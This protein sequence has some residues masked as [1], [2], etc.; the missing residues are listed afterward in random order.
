MNEREPIADITAEKAFFDAVGIDPS[1][2]LKSSNPEDDVEKTLEFAADLLLQRQHQ[3]GYWM[4]EL[5]ADVTIPSEY[6]LLQLF[7]GKS[8]DQIQTRISRYLLKAQ[9]TDGSWPLFYDGEG[10]IS[11]TVKAYF[12]LKLAGQDPESEHM[13]LARQWIID[14][15]GAEHCNVFTRITLALFGQIPWRTVPAMPAEIIWIPN[16]WFFSL[17]KVSYWSRCV[18]VPLLILLAYRPVYTLKKNQSIRELF[19]QDPDTLKNLETLSFSNP[20]KSVFYLLDRFI[21]LVQGY[22]PRKIRESSIQRCETWTREHMKGEGGIGAIFPAMANAVM[23][24][25][26]RGCTEDDPDFLRGYMAIQDLVVEKQ[27]EIY[28]QPCVSPIWDTCLT[29]NALAE[30]GVSQDHPGMLKAISWLF[31]KQIFFKGDWARRRPQLNCGAWAF[32]F[33]NDFYPDIDDTSMVVMSLLRCNAHLNPEYFERIKQA[34]DWVIGM[35]NTDGGWGAFDLNNHYEYLNN[36]PF[37]DHGALVDPSTADLTG[38]C[39]E[40]LIMMGYPPDYEPI[41]R[42]LSFL[43]STQEEFGG[44]YGR[45]GV[46]Y[47]YGSWSVLVALAAIGEDPN[48]PYIRKAVSWL[49]S[50]QNEDG[51]WGED[52]NSYD[53]IKDAG[54]GKT[55]PS[56]TSWAL[57][58]LIAA[59]E[60]DSDSVSTGIRYL[61]DSFD[62]ESAWL[63]KYYTGTGFPRVFYLRYHGYSQ[64]FPVWALAMYLGEQSGITSRQQNILE[65]EVISRLLIQLPGK[66]VIGNVKP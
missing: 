24:L 29:L 42:G 53:D 10:N 26:L 3:E 55:T 63:E 21:K 6:L 13:R 43:K 46:N 48:Q 1:L 39:I 56:Q 51:G 32:Q 16:W 25:K 52:C 17:D 50:I 44:W 7:L 14:Q 18:I 64:Y 30:A 33:E 20:I 45:W 31:E 22:I 27:D 5:E 28:V 38:R 19:I 15:G 54:K 40:M 12:A 58:G 2:E 11:A 41:A 36:I 4:Y 62:E 60:S 37:A 9:H 49:K 8:N 65:N 35:Q 61:V 66:A 47:I 57:L 34:I 23:A 59:G